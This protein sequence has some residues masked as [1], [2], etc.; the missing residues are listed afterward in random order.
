MVI[1][2]F[3]FLA[4]A[5]A[6]VVLSIAIPAVAAAANDNPIISQVLYI[7]AGTN[8]G[9]EAVELYNPAPA[10]VNITGWVLAT[11]TSPTDAIVPEGTLI[12]SGCYYLMADSGWSGSKDNLSWPNADYEEAI[13]LANLDA[14][15]ALKDING[16]VV[17][18]VGW[19]NPAN[20]GPGLYE[21][22]P[23]SGSG[24]GNALA[25]KFAGG[26]YVDTGNNSDDFL[27][28]AP[29]LH[30]SSLSSSSA[31]NSAQIRVTIV[32]SGSS[33][34]IGSLSILSDDDALLPGTQLSPIPKANRTVV[35]EAV[36]SDSNG[37]PDINSVT[38][39]FAGAII[40]M[41][42]GSDIN[43]TAAT[44]FAT[45][46]LTSSFPAGNHTITA[47]AADSSGFSSNY[48]VS[49]EYLTLIAF[50]AEPDSLIFFATPGSAYEL[51]GNASAANITLLNS[52]NVK[53][54]FDIWSSNFTS[55]NG[56]IE[57]SM[58]QYTFNGNYNDAAF[59]GN[60]TN[61]KARK[62]INLN[63]GF[64]SG[65]SIKLKLPLATVPGNYSGMI[66]LVAVDS[67]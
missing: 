3:S 2:L 53:L 22:V 48:S 21:G 52:G 64:M 7:P 31:A 23:H 34:V 25:R 20:I 49:F 13:T 46:S 11:E 19:G 54:D 59:G 28:S 6:I 33:P 32:V 8:S 47:T 43:S 30:N 57:A 10:S 42:K 14:G 39:R 24:V 41:E 9:G 5:A 18:A 26:S 17:D 45:L 51:A 61:T 44:Y 36:V 38:L 60:M 50:E 4:V 12:C 35:V 63:P 1:K 40:N 16:I 58:L 29:N 67:G 56:V 66:S 37:V 62:A 15:V 27:D 55:P 65:L